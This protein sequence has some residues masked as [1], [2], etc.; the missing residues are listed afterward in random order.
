MSFLKQKQDQLEK[1]TR[2]FN[3]ENLVVNS[4]MRVVSSLTADKNEQRKFSSLSCKLFEVSFLYNSLFFPNSIKNE[5]NTQLKECFELV[6]LTMKESKQVFEFCSRTLQKQN[7]EQREIVQ[8]SL[9]LCASSQEN[10][11]L[12]NLL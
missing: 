11:I 4:F 10:E 7:L 9:C 6:E 1:L 8:L 12:F 2:N 3:Q 5:I